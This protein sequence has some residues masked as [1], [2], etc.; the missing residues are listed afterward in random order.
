[1]GIPGTP[2]NAQWSNPEL[3]TL[4]AWRIVEPYGGGPRVVAERNPFYFKVGTEGHQLPYVDRLVYDVYQ[5]KEA[6]VLKALNGEIDMQDRHIA[7][8]QNKAVF[9]DN[10][11]KGGY[12]FYEVTGSGNTSLALNLTHKD[13]VRRQI[14]QH[15]DFRIGLSHAINRQEVSDVVYVGQGEPYQIAPGPESVFYNEKLAKQYTEYDVKK[16][17]AHLDKVLPNKDGEGFRLGPDG[18]RLSFT[19]EVTSAL[20]PTWAD[21]VRGRGLLAQGRGRRAREGRR[22]PAA[23]H[24]QE[25]Q[26]AR[27]G[28]LG[29]RRRRGA[30]HDPGPAL[31]KT[32]QRR[33]ELRR[34]L[35]ELVP[36]PV[37]AGALT[38]P[39]EP[40]PV[41][42]Q[43]M[44]LYRQLQATATRRSR[45]S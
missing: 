33:V 34:G 25:R 37:G 43:Q 14:F 40:P 20:D 6:L 3:P 7:T 9:A 22:P 29:R 16:A 5:D 27:R 2:Y 1:M 36:Q 23:V 12:R 31:V 15:Q 44:E 26:R 45:S 11:Q 21:V 28:R 19:I 17:N 39:E 8:L 10:R 38:A 13:P 32:L 41:V 30:R 42:K 24:P 18:K 4:H 35:G